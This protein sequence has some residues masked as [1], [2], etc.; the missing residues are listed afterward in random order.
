LRIYQMTGTV[1]NVEPVKCAFMP[2]VD[3]KKGKN[4]KK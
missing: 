2:W 4:A 1:P 3:P